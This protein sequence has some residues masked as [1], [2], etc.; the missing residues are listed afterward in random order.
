MLAAVAEEQT[1][2]FDSAVELMSMCPD[3]N[4]FEINKKQQ[5][6]FTL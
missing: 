5:A 2:R 1:N 4:K 3:Y 6:Y